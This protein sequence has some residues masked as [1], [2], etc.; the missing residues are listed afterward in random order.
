MDSRFPYCCALLSSPTTLARVEWDWN[1]KFPFASH[2]TER[3]SMTTKRQAREVIYQNHFVW[4]VSCGR[5]EDAFLSNWELSH[6]LLSCCDD[7]E[8][9]FYHNFY[10]GHKW[11][12]EGFHDDNFNRSRFSRINALK[13]WE[14]SLRGEIDFIGLG[15]DSIWIADEVESRLRLCLANWIRQ[16]R[17]ILL[18]NYDVQSRPLLSFTGAWHSIGSSVSSGKHPW[19]SFIVQWKPSSRLCKSLENLRDSSKNFSNLLMTL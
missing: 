14:R 6:F 19:K 1:C 11:Q 8:K 3:G 9:Q 17:E 16:R 12:R 7:K 15:W 2:S 13:Q 5:W 4:I 18:R 10:Y